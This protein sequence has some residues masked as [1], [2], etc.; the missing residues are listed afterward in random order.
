MAETYLNT[1]FQYSDFSMDSLVVNHPFQPTYYLCG[2]TGS[3]TTSNL[4]TPFLVYAG[5]YKP[6]IFCPNTR[7]FKK[8]SNKPLGV[9][10][11]HWGR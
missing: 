8:F 9:D 2:G 7:Q 6:V 1:T 4:V 5:N 11:W 3:G 10:K